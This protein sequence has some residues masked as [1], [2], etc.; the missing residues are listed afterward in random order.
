LHWPEKWLSGKQVQRLAEPIGTQLGEAET[1]R[2][3]DW[4]KMATKGLR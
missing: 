3:A 1:A 4:W 2:I